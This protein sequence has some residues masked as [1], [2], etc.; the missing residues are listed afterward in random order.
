MAY[1]VVLLESIPGV[2]PTQARRQEHLDY[3]ASLRA[4]GIL[5]VAGRFR[6]GSGGLYVL[7]AKDIAEAQSYAESDPYVKYGIRRCTVK[8]WERVY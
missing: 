8:E 3:L 7:E 5:F 2:Q 6:D 1:F 4:R